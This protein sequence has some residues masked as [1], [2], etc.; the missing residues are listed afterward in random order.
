ML[1]G[2]GLHALQEVGWLPLS[3]VPFV[4]IDLLG[5]FPDAYSLVP[6]AV[7]ALLPLG[8]WLATRSHR[9]QE[10]ALVSEDVTSQG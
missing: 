5:I 2:K 7:L 1:L 4:R 8:Y 6:Q 9:A 3:P 10:A